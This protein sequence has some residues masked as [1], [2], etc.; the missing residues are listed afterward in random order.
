M[1]PRQSLTEHPGHELL[2]CGFDFQSTKL[3]PNAR[4][5]LNNI[6]QAVTPGSPAAEKRSRLLRLIEATAFDGTRG[7]YVPVSHHV[8]L[9]GKLPTYST[10]LARTDFPTEPFPYC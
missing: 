2:A 4:Q 8:A 6:L 9:K 3:S 1:N 10:Q 5:Q 7:L